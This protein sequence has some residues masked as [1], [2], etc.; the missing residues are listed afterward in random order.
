MK[1]SPVSLSGIKSSEDDILELEV[2]LNEEDLITTEIIGDPNGII[3]SAVIRS[4]FGG[5]IPIPLLDVFSVSAIQKKMVEELSYIYQCDFSEAELKTWVAALM[6]DSGVKLAVLSIK[7][8]P[9]VG[10]VIGGLSMGLLSGACTYAIGKVF[11]HHFKSGGTNLNFDP[12]KFKN[13]F[14]IQFEEGKKYAEGL[15]EN[16]KK[17]IP[18]VLKKETISNVDLDKSENT[19]SFGILVSNIRDIHGL[20]NTGII[21]IEE[22]EYLKK[23]IILNYT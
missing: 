16:L 9:G 17:I 8:I 13:Y 14:K 18:S 21:S 1:F 11:A 5:L 22:F 7:R 19:D 3:R 12:E 15:K 23:K 4:F 6:A 20:M 10:M 2:I